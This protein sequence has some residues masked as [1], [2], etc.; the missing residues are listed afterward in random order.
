LRQPDSPE[1]FGTANAPG[2]FHRNSPRE[3]DMND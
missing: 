1:G 3:I 2:G